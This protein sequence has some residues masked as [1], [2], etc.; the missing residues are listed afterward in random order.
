M[1]F[2]QIQRLAIAVF[3]QPL[4]KQFCIFLMI[5]I[6]YNIYHNKA[7][8]YFIYR[9][10]I[11]D[12]SHC[13]SVMTCLMMFLGW[14]QFTENAVDWLNYPFVFYF[15]VVHQQSTVDEVK[16]LWLR[17]WISILNW[18]KLLTFWILTLLLSWYNLTYICPL[19]WFEGESG[20]LF[21][22]GLWADHWA[23]SFLW[24][25]Q[26]STKLEP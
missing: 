14:R 26:I 12:I 21:L 4:T 2:S 22:F 13:L 5:N 25:K 3:T 23:I 20:C 1:L 6:L 8:F 17:V 7:A 11:L 15:Q 9:C 18:I 16:C 24:M 19:C 10:G